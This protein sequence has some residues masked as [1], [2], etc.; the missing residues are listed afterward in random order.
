[1]GRLAKRQSFLHSLIQIL[2]KDKK[3]KHSG[4]EGWLRL[5][6]LAAFL[7][8]QGSVPSTHVA[9][10]GSLQ[11]LFQKTQH[12]LLASK[13]TVNTIHRCT[14]NPCTPE[15]EAGR[16]ATGQPEL[17]SEVLP[18]KH[19]TKP[20]QTQPLAKATVAVLLRG[21]AAKLPSKYLRLCPQNLADLHA[22]QV[23]FFSLWRAAVNE[24]MCNWPK[25]WEQETEC[26]ALCGTSVR[27]PPPPRLR[28]HNRGG[29]GK[30]VR[31]EGRGGCEMLSS[32]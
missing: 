27:T 6:A 20:N 31:A 15:A 11:L 4:L 17:Q 8:D 30:K 23:K 16:S 19:Q 9:A 2:D 18:Q 29:G 24:E 28:E 21:Y 7:W 32:V 5:K 22:G 25:D 12:P 10:A 3:N 26:S 14:F 1:M 13:N